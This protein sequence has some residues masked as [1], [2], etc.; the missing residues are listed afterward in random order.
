MSQP[1]KVLKLFIT[2]NDDKKRFEKEIIEIDENGVLGD[3]FYAKNSNRLILVTTLGA[4]A[5]AKD[6]E[7]ELA[8]GALG[9]NILIDTDISHLHAGDRFQIGEVIL[10][11]TQ[12]CTL[13]NGLS[14][15][16]KKL[17]KIL[18]DDRGVFVKTLTHGTIKIGDK[19]VA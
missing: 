19:I 17:P 7:I 15:L 12:N 3:K 4:Y 11:I 6:K 10:E 5:L 18:K 16:D 9:E 2:T 1:N 13:C 14:V 8:H